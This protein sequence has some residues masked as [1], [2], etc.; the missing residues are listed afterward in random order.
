MTEKITYYAL[1]DWGGT[2][3]QPHGLVRRRVVDGLVYD[4]AYTR[5][6]RREPTEYFELYRLGHD[7]DRYEQ[8]SKEDAEAFI[9]H[10][11]RT[12]RDHPEM[13]DVAR[14]IRP[15]AVGIPLSAYTRD[16][17]PELGPDLTPPRPGG[18]S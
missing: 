9:D 5:Q 1:Y 7:D 14:V 8:I 6:S 17:P 11:E 15:P 2:P 3:N 18:P 4:E 16:T 12:L 10:M 13:R